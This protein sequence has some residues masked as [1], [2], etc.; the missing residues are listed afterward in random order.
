MTLRHAIDYYMDGH[1][2]IAFCKNCSAEGDKLFDECVGIPF[3]SPLDN[4]QKILDQ[5]RDLIESRLDE[6]N[7]T[8]K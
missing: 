3:V 8:V 4:K 2:A 7:Q 6:M 1:I 5:E